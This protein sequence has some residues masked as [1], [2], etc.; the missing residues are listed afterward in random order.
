M[1]IRLLKDAFEFRTRYGDQ[2]GAA[3]IPWTMRLTGPE[4]AHYHFWLPDCGKNEMQLAKWKVM[5]KRAARDKGD[6]V[7]FSYDY[8][9]P[10]YQAKWGA[11]HG[12]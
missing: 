10:D 8:M 12:T 6:P 7:S 9:P 11:Q 1:E 4:G 3:P 2:I 5:A